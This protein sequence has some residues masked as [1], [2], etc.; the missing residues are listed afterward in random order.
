[1]RAVVMLVFPMG[2]YYGLLPL[3][4]FRQPANLRLLVVMLGVFVAI[5]TVVVFELGPVVF[6]T[7]MGCCS[8]SAVRHAICGPIGPGD[9]SRHSANFWS[10]RAPPGVAT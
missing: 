6:P 1:M 5:T 8:P 7:S 4:V 3:R 2:G 10:R 9:I